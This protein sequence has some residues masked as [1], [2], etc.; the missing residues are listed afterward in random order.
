MDH[1]LSTRCL[2]DEHEECTGKTNPEYIGGVGPC[3][4]AC[5][6]SDEQEQR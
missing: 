2:L 3:A 6:L 4:C 1:G 5:H